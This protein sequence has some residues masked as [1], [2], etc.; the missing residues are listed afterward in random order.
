MNVT[1]AKGTEFT[2]NCVKPEVFANHFGEAAPLGLALRG[3]NEDG[4]WL[5][6]DSKNTFYGRFDNDDC[7]AQQTGVH[8]IYQSS[9]PENS[10]SIIGI[11]LQY[12]A[13]DS[14]IAQVTPPQ[15]SDKR[16]DRDIAD[17]KSILEG[18]N[19]EDS[20][21]RIE[22]RIQLSQ[23]TSWA[24]LAITES[25]WNIV[26]GSYR[27]D[28]GRLI[29]WN[30]AVKR[31]QS[32]GSRL[33]RT[34]GKDKI[35]HVIYLTGHQDI[36]MRIAATA[37]LSKLLADAAGI[38]WINSGP[39][40]YGD[41]GKLTPQ[42]PLQLTPKEG[43]TDGNVVTSYNNNISKVSYMILVRSVKTVQISCGVPI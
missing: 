31:D 42:P 29:A 27:D 9:T 40:T 24:D 21:V 34:L 25:N 2:I 6:F 35:E 30:D 26:S 11:L 1:T 22:S 38:E 10:R 17:I 41:G 23:R 37:F 15:P 43:G 20:D 36:T 32:A 3:Q 4:P 5:I 14:A 19:S 8:S 12:I 18:L 7:D 33:I 16:K 13:V 39:Q 28:L